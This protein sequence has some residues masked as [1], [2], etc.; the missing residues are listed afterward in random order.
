MFTTDWSQE[1][2]GKDRT[3]E[4]AKIEFSGFNFLYFVKNDF[5]YFVY[6]KYNIFIG[7][8]SQDGRKPQ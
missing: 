1:K 8:S 4:E 7:K 2:E 3:D 6:M 5:T